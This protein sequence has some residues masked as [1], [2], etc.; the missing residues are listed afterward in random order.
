M[1]LKMGSRTFLESDVSNRRARPDLYEKL[2]K[3]DVNAAT[4][5][6]HKVKAITKLR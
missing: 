1:D 3:I 2:I 5:D 4:D 6:E